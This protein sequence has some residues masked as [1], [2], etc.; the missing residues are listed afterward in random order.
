MKWR[1]VQSSCGEEAEV[2]WS[3]MKRCSVVRVGARENGM[4]TGGVWTR[5]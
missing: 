1:A 2:V 4:A 5:E 3:A